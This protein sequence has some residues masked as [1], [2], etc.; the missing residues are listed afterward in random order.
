MDNKVR[1]EFNVKIRKVFLENST[2]QCKRCCSI[3]NLEVHHII[4]ISDGGDNDFNNLIVLCKSCHNEWHKTEQ[5]YLKFDDFIKKPP[6]E[7]DSIVMPRIMEN[8]FLVSNF[9][10]TKIRNLTFDIYKELNKSLLKLG[11]K[12][13]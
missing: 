4:P 2:K 9:G 7:I 5:H 1:K 10:Y 11:E 3:K 6:S 8:E 12:V 13:I